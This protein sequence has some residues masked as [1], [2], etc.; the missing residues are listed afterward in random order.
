MAVGVG[1]STSHRSAQAGR[2]AAAQALE[3]LGGRRADL[4]LVF[5]TAGY[6]QMELVRAVSEATG[7]APLAGCSA[8]GVIDRHGSDEGS[9]AVSVM[10]I[11]SDRMKIRTAR[12]EGFARDPAACGRKLAEIVERS[13]DL[14]PRLLLLFADGLSGNCTR[15][16]AALDPALPRGVTVVGG[17]AGDLLD[18][19]RTWQYEG[20]EAFSD[21]ISAVVVGGDVEADVKVSHG[22]TPIGIEH[23]I[24]RASGGNVDE[25]DDRP[26]W[27]VVR[28][29]LDGDDFNALAVTYCCFAERLPARQGGD[30][31][32]QYIVRVPLRLDRTSGALF[33]PGDIREGTTVVMARRDP[34]KVC[35]HAVEAARELR[36]LRPDRDPTLVLQ[37][38]CAGRGR[39]MFGAHTT[40]R[41]IEPVQRVFETDR[42]TVPWIG[43]HSYGEIAPIAGGQ[44]YYHN[45]TAVL[46]ALYEGRR[47]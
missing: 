7:R 35:D 31:Y 17:T 42:G 5:A 24:T 12:V 3:A 21:G 4:V 30:A 10:A 36:A 27:S 47:G 46:C 20:S 29:Y 18:L 26:A 40:A 39:I 41:L 44:T 28:E 14:S 34:A 2:E 9:H 45:Y 37:V 38:D 19:Q 43:F 11:A 16:L 1:R 25:I 6:D 8:E 15:L 32:G 23:V 13:A 33:F 22:C